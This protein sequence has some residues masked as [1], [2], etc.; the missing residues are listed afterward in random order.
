MKSIF[1]SEVKSSYF[2]LPFGKITVACCSCRS[3]FSDS[4]DFKL[5]KWPKDR[6]KKLDP[7]G[8]DQ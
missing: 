2:L 1:L 6:A 8:S 4:E 3:W 5:E 7:G